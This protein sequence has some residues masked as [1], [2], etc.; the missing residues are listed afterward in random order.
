M[1]F[2]IEKIKKYFYYFGYIFFIISIVIAIV[3][4]ASYANKENVGLAL[5]YMVGIIFAGAFNGLLCHAIG[6]LIQ[7]KNKTSNDISEI[8]DILGSEKNNKITE[9]PAEE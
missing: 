5:M 8:K 2:D 7:I 3:F 9:V 6:T 1:N 4:F